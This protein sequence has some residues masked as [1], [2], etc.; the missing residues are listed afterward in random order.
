MELGIS[1]NHKYFLNV[2]KTNAFFIVQLIIIFKLEAS[3]QGDQRNVSYAH[4][5]AKL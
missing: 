2:L 5:T 4:Y 1:K 3:S